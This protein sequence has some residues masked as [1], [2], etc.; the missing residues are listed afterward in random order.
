M[1]SMLRICEKPSFFFHQ[2]GVVLMSTAD[3]NKK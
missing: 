3:S 1:N 2:L